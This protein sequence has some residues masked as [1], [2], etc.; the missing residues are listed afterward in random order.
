MSVSA[1]SLDEGEQPDQLT[2][3]EIQRLIAAYGGLIAPTTA[4][5]TR[6]GE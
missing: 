6:Y 3:T 2:T 1:I 5:R 4:A